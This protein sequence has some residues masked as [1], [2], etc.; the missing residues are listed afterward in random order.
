MPV[1]CPSFCY[2][3]KRASDNLRKR[4]HAE[5]V[6]DAIKAALQDSD[7]CYDLVQQYLTRPDGRHENE[8]TCNRTG[9]SRTCCP[10]RCPEVRGQRTR[11]HF[12]ITQYV[13]RYQCR[14]EVLKD[15]V[16]EMMAY[17]AFEEHSRSARGNY[18]SPA[19]IAKQWSEWVEIKNK[20]PDSPEI[21]WDLLGPEEWSLRFW[22][23]TRDQI[24]YRSGAA[25]MKE[26]ETKEK[27]MKN[28]SQEQVASLVG[29]IHTGHN[30]VAFEA[31]L[32]AMGKRMSE[33]QSTFG[34]YDGFMGR[35]SD[36]LQ[37]EKPQGAPSTPLNA[38]NTDTMQS[39]DTTSAGT[40]TKRSAVEST[41]GDDPKRMRPDDPPT[42]YFDRDRALAQS[43]RNTK[44]ANQNV[45]AQLKTTLDKAALQK[46]N[47]NSQEAAMRTEFMREYKI[48]ESRSDCLAMVLDDKKP[49]LAEILAAVDTPGNGVQ[50]PPCKG[51]KH[52]VTVSEM[53]AEI[54]DKKF[55]D[56]ATKADL[57]RV[58][59]CKDELLTFWEC[60][61]LD[62]VILVES[63]QTSKK[64]GETPDVFENISLGKNLQG[65]EDVN[66]EEPASGEQGVRNQTD[67]ASCR[68]KCEF[69]WMC[70]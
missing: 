57:D 19:A 29:R 36:F 2:T 25:K 68:G 17:P 10:E 6:G 48:L 38:P 18:M 50:A 26:M 58:V 44:S 27:G 14:T 51:Y 49:E 24:T 20:D 70:D 8:E 52:L 45:R 1:N 54:V 34:S 22:V 62:G 13:E 55:N 66:P 28:A 39:G 59:V 5:G 33:N 32:D 12:S 3:C 56:V 63:S 31:D 21:V 69:G 37:T 67:V 53:S 9:Q 11:G 30:E 64:A 65:M 23:H 40:S 15:A 42:P 46:T 60:Y 43:L 7:R 35:V 4:A 47:F 41:S 61:T 16:G